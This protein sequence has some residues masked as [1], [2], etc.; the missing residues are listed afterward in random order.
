MTCTKSAKC[1]GGSTWR[2]DVRT[3]V[4]TMRYECSRD[5]E[6]SL[7]I[8]CCETCQGLQIRAKE[9]NFPAA[10]VVQC[11]GCMNLKQQADSFGCTVMAGVFECGSES[12]CEIGAPQ[13]KKNGRSLRLQC[14][15]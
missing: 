3:I 4:K 12:S 8:S 1:T 9:G 15:S 6:G 11:A 14:H 10:D 2:R 13:V 5:C 7:I